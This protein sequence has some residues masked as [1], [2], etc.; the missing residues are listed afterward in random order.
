MRFLIS[1][2]TITELSRELAP[3]AGSAPTASEM[4]ESLRARLGENLDAAR[5]LE[6]EERRKGP[7]GP[8]NLAANYAKRDSDTLEYIMKNVPKG[9]RLAPVWHA[10]LDDNQKRLVLNDYK[11]VVRP[12]LRHVAT[13]YPHEL[14]ALGIGRRGIRELQHGLEPFDNDH[15]PYNLSID[16]IVERGGAGRRGV[17]KA[18]DPLNPGALKPR[19][20]VNH[21]ENMIL[22]PQQVHDFKNAL[23]H[24]QM[25]SARLRNKEQWVLTLAP[26]RDE[27]N[28]GFV[29]PPQ[30]AKH[31]L[32]GLQ[33]RAHT[34]LRC[35]VRAA[36]AANMTTAAIGEMKSHPALRPLMRLFRNIANDNRGTV[37]ELAVE[38]R[39]GVPDLAGQF[40]D[41]AAAEPR[42]GAQERDIVRPAIAD[43]AAQIAHVFNETAAAD[44]R[45]EGAALY[46]KF[47]RFHRSGNLKKLRRAV[48]SLP[49]AEAAAMMDVL[50]D[51]DRRF[52]D[53]VAARR[54][55]LVP[56]GPDAG[57]RKSA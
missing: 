39:T 31:R 29:C 38:R 18:F 23:L 50:R 7:K 53:M 37:A 20:L 10:P 1:A 57:L 49:F 16:H 47:R 41:V 15:T 40:A 4:I 36:A 51:V 3:D 35:I 27:N 9:F 25:P 33:R 34:A 52:E 8:F 56:P 54:P 28:A 45:P 6:R 12:F 17:D 48:G 32:R 30:P 24:L 5:I 13:H 42:I 44:G 22:L 46:R 26:V 55:K 11:S 21:F 14:A 19:Y 43:M 2:D